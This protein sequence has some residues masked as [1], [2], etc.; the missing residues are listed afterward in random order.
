MR[1]GATFTCRGADGSVHP[2]PLR[3]VT[4]DFC[5]GKGDPNADFALS[6]FASLMQSERNFLRSLP[7][8]PLASACL[9]HSSDCRAVLPSRSSPSSAAAAG[10]AGGRRAVCAKA[11]LASRERSEGGDGHAGRDR[12]HGSTYG[13]GKGAQARAAMHEPH[14]NEARPAGTFAALN[15]LRR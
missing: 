12:H 14:M 15:I 4:D 11:E 5:P 3:Y 6:A 10:A 8:R 2:A 7:C 13:V 1:C 9:E